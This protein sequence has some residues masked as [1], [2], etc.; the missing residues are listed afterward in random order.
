MSE[1]LRFQ[2]IRTLGDYIAAYRLFLLRGW[3][4]RIFWIFFS[5]F[6]VVL[7]LA[8]TVSVIGGKYAGLL[9]WLDFLVP[10]GIYLT[11]IV[12]LFFFMP[13][14]SARSHKDIG[15]ACDVAVDANEIVESNRLGSVA[16]SWAIFS[17]AREKKAMFLLYQ[18]RVRLWVYPKRGLSLEIIDQLRELIRANIPKTKLHKFRS[19]CAKSFDSSANQK[20]EAQAPPVTL[21][22]GV[23]EGG[24]KEKLSFR[25]TST[26]EDLIRG[27]RAH[28]RRSNLM[29]VLWVLLFLLFARAIYA[30]VTEL[31]G[32]LGV[33][34]LFTD[35]VVYGGL[36]GFV[37]YI[38]P[39]GCVRGAPGLNE[40]YLV[41]VGDDGIEVRGTLASS[42]AVWENFTAASETEEGFLLYQGSGRFRMFPKRSLS[43][44][45]VTRFR[46]ML[47]DNI[48]KVDLLKTED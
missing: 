35:L 41:S 2:L 21:D 9:H 15:M 48:P 12:F 20:L 7:L 27:F 6:I 30:S 14:R 31:I 11:F 22:R 19:T 34:P 37:Y 18:G 45:E 39:A 44:G 10:V 5:L 38:V 24:R 29:R 28:M 3:I 43:A 36:F 32:G 23:A 47:V 42:Y 33:G 46:M 17:E 13:F 16:I 1:L 26:K 4:V 40:D 8:R 25:I